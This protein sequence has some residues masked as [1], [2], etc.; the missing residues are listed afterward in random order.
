M[1]LED[2]FGDLDDQDTFGGNDY[3]SI[4]FFIPKERIKGMAGGIARRAKKLITNRLTDLI[5]ESGE[6]V[7]VHGCLSL[8]LE[9]DRDMVSDKVPNFDITPYIIYIMEYHAPPYIFYDYADQLFTV[10][11]NDPDL[12]KTYGVPWFIDV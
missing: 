6:E 7:W 11:V 2:E 5:E 4:Y 3:I 8:A 9:I 12:N 10:D 1:I